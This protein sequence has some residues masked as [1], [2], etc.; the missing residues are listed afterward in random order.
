EPLAKNSPRRQSTTG[1]AEMIDRVEIAC[2]AF[3]RYEQIGNDDVEALIRREQ[4]MPRVVDVNP[5]AIVAENAG[6]RRFELPR[7]GGDFGNQFGNVNGLDFVVKLGARR[8]RG[9]AHAE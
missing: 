9:G 6:V 4:K 1:D 2:F 8:R 3:P 7:G 5:C